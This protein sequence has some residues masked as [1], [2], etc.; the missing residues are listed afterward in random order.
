MFPL[1]LAFFHPLEEETQRL[2]GLAH[3]EDGGN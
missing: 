3:G 2:P 1:V